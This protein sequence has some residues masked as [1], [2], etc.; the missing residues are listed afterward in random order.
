MPVLSR[1]SSKPSEVREALSPCDAADDESAAVI[2][3]MA[4]A[5]CPPH[6]PARTGLVAVDVADDKLALARKHGAAYLVNAADEVSFERTPIADG[7]TVQV[8]EAV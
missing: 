4:G 3:E 8:G 1:P 6:V 2:D 5:V 7:E